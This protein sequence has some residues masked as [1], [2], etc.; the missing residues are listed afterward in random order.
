MATLEE[1]EAR[2]AA[3]EQAQSPT[4]YYTSKYS[5]EEMDALLDKVAAMEEGETG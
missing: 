4:E 5:G 3:L 1:L 2:I